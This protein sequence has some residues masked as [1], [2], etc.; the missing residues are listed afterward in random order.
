MKKNIK[1]KI[2][3]KPIWKIGMGHNDHISGSGKH[4]SRPKRGR[5]RKANFDKHMKEFDYDS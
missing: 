4:D 2:N 3:V 1:I 5:T